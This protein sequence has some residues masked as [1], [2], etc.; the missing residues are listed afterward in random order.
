M[1]EFFIP[2][3]II[4]L[5]SVAICV[6]FLIKEFLGISYFAGYEGLY[7]RQSMR[8]IL[9]YVFII[10]LA[11]IMVIFVLYLAGVVEIKRIDKDDK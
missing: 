4:T 8:I 6:P 11:G 3:C 7:L 10:F 1:N 2:A 9:K 5:I